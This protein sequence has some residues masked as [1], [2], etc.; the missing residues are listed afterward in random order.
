M[1]SAL[2]GGEWSEAR[3]GRTLPPGKTR[4]TLYRRLGGPQG[5]S[6]QA[7]K[8]TLPPGFD[9]WTVHPVVSR[10]TDWAT[11]PSFINIQGVSRLVDITAGGDFVGLSDQKISYKRVSDF[12]R[13]RSYGH[14]LIPV[15]ALVWTA[16]YEISLDAGKV[17]PG[18][19]ILHDRATRAVH[20][21]GAAFVAAGGGI[22]EN[23]L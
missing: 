12:G 22:F 15:H 17:G 16:S 19:C 2:E 14:F 5:R 21:R 7:R 10:Y 6:R 11:R 20:N 1:T 18:Q 23:Q 3:L 9:P 13:L 4:Y 8:L